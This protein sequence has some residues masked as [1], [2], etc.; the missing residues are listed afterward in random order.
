MNVRSL[1]ISVL[2]AGSGLL[3]GCSADDA[4]RQVS[5]KANV[6]P[7][8]EANCVDCHS[9]PSGEGY[10]TSGLRMNSYEAL[11]KGTKYGPIIVPGSSVSS[12]L[13]RLVEGRADPSLTMPH[14]ESMLSDVQIAVLKKWVDQGA[15]DN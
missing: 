2:A 6:M 14:N 8:L 3:L 11:M 9:P 15:Q 13:I 10:I 12:T 5:F 7:I 4:T 1:L